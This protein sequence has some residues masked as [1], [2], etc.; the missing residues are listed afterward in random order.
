MSCIEQSGYEFLVFPSPIHTHAFHHPA[1]PL[2]TLPA[3]RV[4]SQASIKSREYNVTINTN[5]LISISISV[6]MHSLHDNSVTSRKKKFTVL[7]GRENQ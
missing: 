6:Y 3:L 7:I 1:S 5:Q 4:G 2:I